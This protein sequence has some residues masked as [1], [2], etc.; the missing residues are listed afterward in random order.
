MTYSCS[1]EDGAASRAELVQSFLS[2]SLGPI[3]VDAG[4]GVALAVQEVFQSICSFLGFHK[5][6]SQRVFACETKRTRQTRE[7]GEQDTEHGEERKKE[8]KSL[9]TVDALTKRLSH[10]KGRQDHEVKEEIKIQND[11]LEMETWVA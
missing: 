8:Y 6:Q 2:V 11:N 4:A 7:E 1:H 3:P 10:Y 9:I 5:H